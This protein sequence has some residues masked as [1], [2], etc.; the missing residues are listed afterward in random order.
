MNETLRRLTTLI[1]NFF[2]ILC[3]SVYLS[4]CTQTFPFTNILHSY[5]VEQLAYISPFNMTSSICECDKPLQ[6]LSTCSTY[7]YYFYPLQL[8]LSLSIS[9]C[10]SLSLTLTLIHE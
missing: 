8:F 3:S 6:P 5:F 7:S 1:F 4:I 2:F 10:L 9:P